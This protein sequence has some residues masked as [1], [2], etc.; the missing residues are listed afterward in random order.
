MKL[1][2]I[3]TSPMYT[4]PDGLRDPQYLRYIRLLP[5]VVCC[6]SR[7]VE[8][9]HTGPHGIGQKAPD[10]SAIPL[11]RK[12][13]RMGPDSYH[14]LGPVAFQERHRIDIA[15]LVAMFNHFYR[16]KIGRAA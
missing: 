6:T 4:K 8:A 13:H 16:T 9:A 10:S 5:C 15:G 7:G 14:Q 2:K 12:H 11:C 1:W 3:S